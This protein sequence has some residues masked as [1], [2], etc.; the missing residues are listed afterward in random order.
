MDR[1]I[2]LE[3]GGSAAGSEDASAQG[4]TPK[5]FL[6]RAT[7][8]FRNIPVLK[9]VSSSDSFDDGESNCLSSECAA[10]EHEEEE[11]F[12]PEPMISSI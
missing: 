4:K 12:K 8:D 9:E 5:S 2:Q 6:R 11:V 10:H 3:G 1:S 7:T